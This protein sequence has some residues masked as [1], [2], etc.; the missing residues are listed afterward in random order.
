MKLN[1][2]AR[3][4]STNR[5]TRATKEKPVSGPEQ[6]LRHTDYPEIRAMYE[7]E[8]AEG[9]TPFRMPPIGRKQ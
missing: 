2:L 4:D 6:A 1:Q 7:A 3:L 9:G 5:I 8:V